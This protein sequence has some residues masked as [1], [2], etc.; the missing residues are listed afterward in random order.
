MY[1][2]LCKSM[3]DRLTHLEATVEELKQ[4]FRHYSSGASQ[5]HYDNS[6]SQSL[7]PGSAKT[8][9]LYETDFMAWCEGQAEALRTHAY[10]QLDLVHLL[11]E[12]EAMG[13]EQYRKT[14]SL[15]RQILIHMLELRAFPDD[16][17]IN[18]WRSEIVAFQNDLE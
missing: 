7:K 5:R 3:T 14:T 16:P 10:E 15:V 9:D 1:L 11:E 18:H 13:R 4:A 12:I 2:S 8:S 6:V 17:S